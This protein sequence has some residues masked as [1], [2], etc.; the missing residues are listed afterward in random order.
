[1]FIR[2]RWKLINGKKVQWLKKK[3][4]KNSPYERLE[5]KKKKKKKYRRQKLEEKC[6]STECY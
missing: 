6:D 2:K 1:M 5:R 4:K 3:K